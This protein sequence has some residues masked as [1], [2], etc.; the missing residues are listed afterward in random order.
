MRV[1]SY[2][3]RSMRW[4]DLLVHCFGANTVEIARIVTVAFSVAH[5]VGQE[6]HSVRVTFR[7]FRY[8]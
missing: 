4:L 8:S 3:F 2:D 1:W 5:G 7:H 6:G